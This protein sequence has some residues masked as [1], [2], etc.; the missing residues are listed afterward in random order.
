[1]LFSHRAIQRFNCKSSCRFLVVVGRLW[2]SVASAIDLS[3]QHIQ[4]SLWQSKRKVLPSL[5]RRAHRRK[6][7]IGMALWA[8]R[9]PQVLS[10]AE[11]C[12]RDWT[13]KGMLRSCFILEDQSYAMR[14]GL[15]FV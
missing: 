7:G 14:V 6:I 5:Q 15:V 8:L 11:G 12:H 4:G 13:R 2:I 3:A 9:T 1:M 10:T